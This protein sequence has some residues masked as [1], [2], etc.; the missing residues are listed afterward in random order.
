MWMSASITDHFAIRRSNLG[1]RG[2]HVAHRLTEEADDTA[3]S[4]IVAG[5]SSSTR[6]PGA[7]R[8]VVTIGQHPKPPTRDR[9]RHLASCRS[10]DT[11][12]IPK[13]GQLA[14]LKVLSGRLW[15]LDHRFDLS[16]REVEQDDNRLL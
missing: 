1:L 12:P 16:R 13:I 6:C 7:A 5:R 3:I 8:F 9:N 10:R 4:W 14:S 15:K 2:T 11:L